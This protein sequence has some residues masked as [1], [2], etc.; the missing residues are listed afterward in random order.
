MLLITR[1]VMAVC[2]LS[3]NSS[4]HG[5]NDADAAPN[6][7][8]IGV[9]SVG[10][11]TILVNIPAV[12]VVTVTKIRN[13]KARNTHLLILGITDIFTAVSL[14][15][16]LKTFVD[17]NSKIN[18][19]YCLLRMFFFVITFYN[20]V[21]QICVICIDRVFLLTRPSWRYT[22]KYERRYFIIFSVTLFVTSSWTCFI[23]YINGHPHTGEVACKLEGIFCKNL[24][25]FSTLVGGFAVL[26]QAVVISCNVAMIVTLLRHRRK[27]R[28]ITPANRAEIQ[29]H[30]SNTQENHNA[31]MTAE[32]KS[33]LTII[34]INMILI[35]CVTPM[36]FGFLLQGLRLA[37]PI[38]RSTRFLITA[39]SCMN[40]AINPFIYCFRTPEV[41]AILNEWFSKYKARF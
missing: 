9:I 3:S 11:I 33:T 15:P 16:M 28:Q 32:A 13:H 40:S 25:Q 22:A 7:I 10:V 23:F 1:F 38:N 24:Y 6:W 36:N 4:D 17:P 14:F 2:E 21:G 20:S 34:I 27:L 31:K 30:E 37:K 29:S 5:N 39:L 12:I 26:I 8:I 19:W 41:K 18:Y 35:V